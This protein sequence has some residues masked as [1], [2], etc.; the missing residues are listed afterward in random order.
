ML[1]AGADSIRDVIAFPKTQT[2]A[3]PLTDAP[4]E[5]RSSSCA[6]CTSASSCRSRSD[7]RDARDPVVLVHGL[8][9]NGLEFGVLRHR[10]QAQHGYDVHVF[11]YPSMNGDAAEIA[12]ELADFVDRQGRSSERVHLVGHSLGGAIVYKAL[13][14]QGIQDRPGNAV[15]LGSPLGGSRA[16]QGVARFAALRPLLGPHILRELAEPCGRCWGDGR[17]RALGAIAGTR[18]VGTGQ[19]FAHFDDEND[20]TVAVSETVI[21]GL[22]DHIVLPH[23]HVGMLFANDVA[24]PGG[25]FP[26]VWALCSGRED[27]TG[28]TVGEGARSGSFP[29]ERKG[30]HARPEKTRNERLSDR[31]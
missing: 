3:C 27:D 1:M 30:R 4:T 11:S 31:A 6:S 7:G 24:A 8:W 25:A 15:L 21:P 10:L 20:G 9:M 17:T 29:G 5:V 28:R 22:N 23:S 16:A 2:A 14:E 12:A 13:V 18:R 26:P 19:F